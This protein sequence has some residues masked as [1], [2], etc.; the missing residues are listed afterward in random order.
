MVNYYRRTTCRLCFSDDLKEA[1]SL[2]PTVL[3]DHFTD[4]PEQDTEKFPIDLYF[5][6]QCCHIQL[7]D[8]VDQKI[9]FNEDFSYMPSKN[10]GL[11]NHFKEYAKFISRLVPNDI[12]CCIDIGS[13]DGLFLSVLK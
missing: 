6:S 12:K 4:D 5:C 8:V 7:V 2:P 9:L 11:L 1:D 3:G 10:E 13:N